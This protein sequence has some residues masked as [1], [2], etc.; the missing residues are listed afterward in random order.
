MLE[1]VLRR[2]SR[3]DTE[4]LRQIA[5]QL[6]HFIFLLEDVDTV[7]PSTASVCLLQGSD[8]PHERA[9]ARAIGPQQA[10]HPMRN[11]E[12]NI[13]ERFHAIGVSLGETGDIKFHKVEA[14]HAI[15]R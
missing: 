3:V 5:K 2:D 13:I 1:H 12:R 4:L 10:V 7:E 15:L 11:C 9:L 6:A 14:V 8:G